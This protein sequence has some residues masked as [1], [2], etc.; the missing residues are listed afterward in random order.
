[1]KIWK[2]F[3]ITSYFIEY[4]YFF[5]KLWQCPS[6]ISQ[7]AAPAFHSIA[8]EIAGRIL[9][10]SIDVRRELSLSKYNYYIRDTK[11][12]IVHEP[13]IISYESIMDL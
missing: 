4:I 9:T 6:H 11:H 12:I 8:S 7:S 10:Y 1:M 13:I 3:F 2:P 5:Q